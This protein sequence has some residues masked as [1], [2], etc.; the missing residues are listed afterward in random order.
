MNSSEDLL[1]YIFGKIY[2]IIFTVE[3]AHDVKIGWVLITIALF[4]II[5]KS[6][7][8]VPRGNIHNDPETQFEFTGA[9]KKD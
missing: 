8:N 6:V 9:P 7:M 3:I 1:F 2:N 4:I 5:I